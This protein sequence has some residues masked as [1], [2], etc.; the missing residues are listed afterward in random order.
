MVLA[1]YDVN[2]G[3]NTHSSHPP[4]VGAILDFTQQNFAAEGQELS[5]VTLSSFN[6]DPKF[7]GGVKDKVVQAWSK[8]VHGYWTQLIRNTNRAKVCKTGECESSLIPLNHTFVVPGGRFR[9]QCTRL[10]TSG[11]VDTDLSQTTGI[12]SG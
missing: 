1:D 3:N 10:V 2:L 4:T 11:C 5:A 7:L 9:E 6:P 8:T 12:L